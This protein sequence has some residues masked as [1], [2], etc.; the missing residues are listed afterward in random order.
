MEHLDIAARGVVFD[1]IFAA[2]DMAAI[3]ATHALQNLGRKIPDDVAIIGFD[4]IPAAQ[5]VSPALTTVAQFQEQLGRRAAERA[6][7]PAGASGCSRRQSCP[8]RES[9]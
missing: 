9:L 5:L 8:H 6:N 4:D 3:G 2:S 7:R 1:A